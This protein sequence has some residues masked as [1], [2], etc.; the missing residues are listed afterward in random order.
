M[1]CDPQNRLYFLFL[2]PILNETQ[3]VN[4]AFES[5]NQDPVKLLS[6]LTLLIKSLYS[7][8]TIPT[9]QIDSLVT[10]LDDFIDSKAYLG[11]EFETEIV[12]ANLPCNQAKEFVKGALNLFKY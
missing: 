11:Y 1:Y 6:D 7:K 5:S 2:R 10:S 9:A 4:K 8:I 12:R 3:R